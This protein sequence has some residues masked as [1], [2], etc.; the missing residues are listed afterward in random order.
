MRRAFVERLTLNAGADRRDGPQ[1]RGGRG[2]ARPGRRSDR[3]MAAAQRSRDFDRSACRSASSRSSTN[4]GPTSPSTP[5]CWGLKAGNAVVLRGGK[6]ALATQR[7]SRGADRDA[8]WKALES[9]PRRGHL[10]RQSRPRGD[11]DSEAPARGDRLDHSA[12]RQ[13]AEGRAR[14]IRGAA[15]AAFRR[16]LPHLRRSRGRSEDGRG[17]LLQR[18]MQPPVGLQ[19]DGERCWCIARSRRSFCPRIAARM[20]RGRRRAARRRAQLARS[21]PDVTRGHR[22]GLGHRV[23]RPDSGGQSRRFARRGDRVYRA[24]RLGPRRRDRHQR[25][26]T[27]PRAFE[28]EVDS[29]TVYVNA[30]TRFT[31]GFEFGFGAETGISTN[32]LHARGP[33]GLRELTT[34]KY[35]IA[36][37]GQVRT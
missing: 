30:S 26:T 37:N 4:R 17:N 31:D 1:R 11:P 18:Q 12:R 2:A 19:R 34:Y 22:R 10:H 27:P 16:H 25:R 3:E 15:A 23:S 33:M 9:H 6:E 29:A 14:G 20:Q 36:G 7:V 8:L 21:S 35:L 5:A 24:P 32:R 13:G 28:R